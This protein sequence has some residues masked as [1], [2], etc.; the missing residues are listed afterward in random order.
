[1]IRI[2]KRPPVVASLILASVLLWA[3]LNV[4]SVEGKVQPND[5]AEALAGRTCDGP[6]SDP[7]V[8]GNLMLAK[9]ELTANTSDDGPS[10]P[11]PAGAKA[12]LM[13]ARRRLAPF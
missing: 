7:S 12:D 10:G 8:V 4:V 11:N 3:L 6:G 1:M 13:R 2:L 5:R 9:S